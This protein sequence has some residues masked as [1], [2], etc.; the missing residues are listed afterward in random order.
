MTQKLLK[1]SGIG[2]SRLHLAWL[3]SAEAQRF[4][5]ISASVIEN[6]KAQGK[7]DAELFSMELAAAEETLKAETLRWMVGKEVKLLARGDVYG[8]KWEKAR[9]EAILDDVLEREYH[10]QLIRQAIIAGFTSVRAISQRI[11]LELKRISYL[12]ADMEKTNMIEFKGH[13]ECVPVFGA[14]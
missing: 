9:F 10:K 12:L 4:V 14:L 8:R 11:G 3:S 5:D 1:L 2:E 6:V 13:T 7:F